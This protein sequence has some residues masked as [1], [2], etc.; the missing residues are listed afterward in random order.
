MVS[1]RVRVMLVL[2]VVPGPAPLGAQLPV[3]VNGFAGA[4]FNTEANTPSEGG[5]GFSWQGEIGLRYRHFSV[6]G[7]LSQHSTGGT[8]KT[9]VVGAYA[10]FPSYLGDGPVQIYLALG[11]GAYQFLPSRG[12]SRT[13]LGG[14]LGPGVSF[15]FRGTP[16]ALNL[17]ARFHSTFDRLPTIN[18]QQF[19][20]ALAGLELRF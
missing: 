2:L 12:D 9:R 20:S 11:L 8:A 4:A 17:E 3:I 6:G 7:E 15:G 14:S 16:L 18:T 1:S 5:G 19:I 13:T 10:R